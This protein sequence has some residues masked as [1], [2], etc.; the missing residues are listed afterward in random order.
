VRTSR[1]I[2]Y[3]GATEVDLAETVHLVEALDRR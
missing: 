1:D 3:P 2:P